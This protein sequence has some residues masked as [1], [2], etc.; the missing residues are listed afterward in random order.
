MVNYCK[1]LKLLQFNS[2]AIFMYADRDAHFDITKHDQI[3]LRKWKING[4]QIL[5]E[6]ETVICNGF[7]NRKPK[8]TVI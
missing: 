7:K 3:K 5:T 4:N 8:V 1:Q 6:N 2:E